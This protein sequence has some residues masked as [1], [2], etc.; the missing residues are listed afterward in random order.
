[1]ANNSLKK[2]KTADAVKWVIVFILLLGVIAAVVTLFF[3]VDRQTT[4]KRIGAEAYSVGVLDDSGEE[5]DD[6]T[7]IV[8]R[9]AVTTDGLKVEIADDATVTYA[10]YFY[11]ADGEFVS[12]TAD[13]SADF[14]GSAIPENAETAKIVI[15]PTADEDGKVDLTEVL[16]Y[17]GQ[18]T[19]TVNR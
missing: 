3:Q 19:V 7:S 11:D 14:D 18:V 6:D 15:T 13:L 2:H 9:N 17:A 8:T 5:T 1:M 16:G 10:L 4:V 12:K